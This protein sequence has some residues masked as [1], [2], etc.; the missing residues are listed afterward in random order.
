MVGPIVNTRIQS[1]VIVFDV[2]FMCSNF[3]QL[4]HSVNH[5]STNLTNIMLRNKWPAC[6]LW[7]AMQVRE[8]L[9]WKS[10][11]M[12]KL[13]FF[14]IKPATTPILHL[15]LYVGCFIFSQMGR[16]H[17][18]LILERFFALS[19]PRQWMRSAALAERHSPPRTSGVLENRTSQIY[20]HNCTA[21]HL[22][23]TA[24]HSV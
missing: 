16:A 18:D 3:S 5:I 8:W 7:S 20:G 15:H 17:G 13:T 21:H 1:T 24:H 4:F 11:V 10:S 19:A 23:R 12:I 22:D 6:Y 9:I 2:W 14:Y